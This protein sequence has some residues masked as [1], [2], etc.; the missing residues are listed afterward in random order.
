MLLLIAGFVGYTKFQELRKTTVAELISN[1]DH[2]E[3]GLVTVIGTVDDNVGTLGWG[4]Y[5]LVDQDKSVMILTKNG[6]PTS[7][8]TKT[9]TG[10]FRKAVS[11]GTFEAS[12][13]IEGK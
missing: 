9:V 10:K 11:L 4:Y 13:I 2:Y 6:V 12:I 5:K 1:A 8:S 3:G 7:G